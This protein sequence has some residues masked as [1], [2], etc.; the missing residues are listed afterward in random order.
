MSVRKGPEKLDLVNMAHPMTVLMEY[1]RQQNFRLVDLFQK[2][3]TDGSSSLSRKEFKDGM[4]VS[5]NFNFRLSSLFLPY[6]RLA[7]H[8]SEIIIPLC[9]NYGRLNC[10]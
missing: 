7:P 5:W 6:N 4:V 8:I 2:L 9:A 10:D 1:M 3:D